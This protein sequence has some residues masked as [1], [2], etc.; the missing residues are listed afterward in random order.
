MHDALPFLYCMHLYDITDK[1]DSIEKIINDLVKRIYIFDIYTT[2]TKKLTNAVVVYDK[3]KTK[4]TKKVRLQNAGTNVDAEDDEY[5]IFEEIKV[6]HEDKDY[7]SS[8][9]TIRAGIDAD[10]NEI[11][12]IKRWLEIYYGKPC[13]PDVKV[14]FI[15]KK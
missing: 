5:R 9:E 4:H 7:L 10:L 8:E 12:M 11:G 15:S 14:I 1:E 2:H 6:E 13:N 3:P